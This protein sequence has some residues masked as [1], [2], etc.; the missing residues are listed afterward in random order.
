MALRGQPSGIDCSAPRPRR[1]EIPW[2]SLVSSRLVSSLLALL[3]QHHGQH[4]EHNVL[5]SRQN[6]RSV[7]LFASRCWAKLRRS[8]GCCTPK[9]CC[10]CVILTGLEGAVAKVLGGVLERRRDN[11]QQRNRRRPVCSGTSDLPKG[12]AWPD[13]SSAFPGIQSQS[14]SQS[15]SCR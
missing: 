12:S 6:A 15:Q 14:K 11:A 7:A 1:G 3:A 13:T 8:R 4:R 2:S 9:H 10:C 5:S